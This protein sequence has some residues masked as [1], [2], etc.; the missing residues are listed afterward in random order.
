MPLSLAGYR[1]APRGGVC[2]R[3][4]EV[5]APPDCSPVP[6]HIYAN[7]P[8]LIFYRIYASIT[9]GEREGEEEGGEIYTHIGLGS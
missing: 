8:F 7:Q 4:E 3:G 9:W 6:A 5:A 1:Q 2:M